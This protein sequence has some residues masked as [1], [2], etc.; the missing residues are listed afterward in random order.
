[1]VSIKCPGGCDLS[2]AEL[3]QA[4]SQDEPGRRAKGTAKYYVTP[5]LEDWPDLLRIL[6][7]DEAQSLAIIT[8][9]VQHK[10]V[11]GGRAPTTNKKKMGVTTAH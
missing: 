1:M 10:L 6:T 4:R 3:S 7:D 9:R 11:R 8:I 5:R 2:A